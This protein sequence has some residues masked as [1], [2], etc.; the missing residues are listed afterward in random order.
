M[1]EKI[2]LGAIDSETKKYVNPFNA[3][4]DRIY[5]CVDCKKRVILRKGTIRVPHF[6]HYSETNTCT[7]L[8]HPNE[9]QIHK[10]AKLL[11][12]KLL[13][14]KRLI[15]MTWECDNCG[16]FYAFTDISTINY[17][18]DD[19]AVLEYRDKDG[20]WIADVALVNNNKVKY[21]FEI[22]N[23]HETITPRP[24]P[25]FE[26]DASKFIQNIQ[27][28]FEDALKDPNTYGFRNEGDYVIEIPCIRKNIIRRCYGSFC[29]KEPWVRRIPGYYK[30][31][32]DNSCI[33]CKKKDYEPPSDGCTGKFQNEFIRICLDCLYKDIYTKEIRNIY[34]PTIE[35]KKEL[36]WCKNG[37]IATQDSSR[38]IYSEVEN[39]I[40]TF[41]P[42]LINKKGVN[43]KWIQDIC[44]FECKRRQ[45][46]PVYSN[47]AFYAICKIC[48]GNERVQQDIVEKIKSN[49]IKPVEEYLMLD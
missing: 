31:K 11:M 40:L 25:W 17:E 28:L 3:S 20:K 14:E 19:K 42:K 1:S 8:D 49:K 33:I 43:E 37:K 46:N 10:D 12:Q 32:Q 21:I 29:Y 22:K 16:G 5:E 13:N 4:K 26:I 9:A 23:K 35:R 38:E 45:Y 41:I 47:K 15:C 44:C 30:E 18:E 39:K 36:E 6:A 27:E 34:S 24:E 2:R 7:Y 48:L